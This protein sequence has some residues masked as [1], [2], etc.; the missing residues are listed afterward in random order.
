MLRDETSD[1]PA[2]ASCVSRR[3][4]E[5]DSARAAREALSR[6]IYRYRLGA[7]VGAASGAGK[8]HGPRASVQTGLV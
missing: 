4:D 8:S 7:R 2:D 3:R 1:N 5:R 6:L